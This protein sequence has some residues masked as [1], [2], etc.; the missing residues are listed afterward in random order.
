MPAEDKL[1]ELTIKYSKVSGYL[2]NTQK[3]FVFLHPSNEKPE[4]EIEETIPFTTETRR[5]NYLGINLPKETEDLYAENYDTDPS[6]LV[7]CRV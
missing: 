1:L 5:T 3:S 2:T 7:L 4:R 6:M